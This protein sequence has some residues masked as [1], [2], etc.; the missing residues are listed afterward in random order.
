[1]STEVVLALGVLGVTLG[2]LTLF[3]LG[4]VRGLVVCLVAALT[5]APFALLRLGTLPAVPTVGIAAPVPSVTTY[6]ILVAGA[7]AVLLLEGKLQR[8]SLAVL[9]AVLYLLVGV[10]ALW[11]RTPELVSGAVHLLTVAGCWVVGVA[12]GRVLG[13]SDPRT[14]RALAYVLV[15]VTGLLAASV[16]FQVLVEGSAVVRASGIFGHPATLG[17]IAVITTGLLLP[18]SLS[19]DRSTRRAGVWALALGFAMTAPTL[20]R[21]NILGLLVVVVVWAVLQPGVR[22]RNR[23]VLLTVLAGAA[24]VPVLSRLLARFQTDSAGGD[25]PELLAAGLRQ[26]AA[27]PWIGTG[28]NRFV[29][30]VSGHEWIVAQTGYP[31]HNTFVLAAAELGVAGALLMLLPVLVALRLAVPALRTRGTRGDVA[32]GTFAMLAGIASVGLTGWA[33]LQ[34]PIAE[35]LFLVVGVLAGW[36]VALR[37]ADV[38]DQAARAAGERD[39]AAPVTG[40]GRP[41]S[42]RAGP[43][44]RTATR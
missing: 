10:V 39:A 40:E 32:R 23:R 12:V 7:T 25:R 27:D 24:F 21:A 15:A 31:V 30:E 37:R 9:P 18:L 19:P 34:Q 4:R 11:P 28:P 29:T 6:G 35:L 17:K 1:M 20:S 33:V 41:T 22:H 36:S 42:L 3:H 5:V 44:R 14:G 2:G 16:A 26:L 43:A 13:R 38:A 8:L